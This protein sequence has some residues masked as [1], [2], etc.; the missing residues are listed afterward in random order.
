MNY[1]PLEYIY[2]H[3]SKDS[4]TFLLLHGTGGDENDLLGLP[5]Y[6]IDNI[7]VLSVRGNVSENG[8]P[9][10]FKRL[11]MG[12]FDEAD[13]IFRTHELVNFLKDVSAK[14]GFDEKKIIALGYSNGAN[15][16][17][18]LLLLYPEFLAGAIM[19]RPMQP[20]KNVEAVIAQK[21]IPVF[22]SNGNYD[23]TINTANTTKYVE[24]LKGFG[25]HVEDHHLPT[26]HGLTDDDIRLSVE[27]FKKNF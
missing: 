19:Y 10:F 11:S 13:V 27:W 12:V 4:Y 23:P 18:S 7:N 22:M 17:G 9:R 16:A 6:F 14:E 5:K 15:I 3:H 26:S 21:H 1:K 8:M 24:L 2:K 25:F 20:F